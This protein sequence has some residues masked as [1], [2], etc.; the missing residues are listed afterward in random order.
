MTFLFTWL[1]NRTQ[2]SVLYSLVFHASLSTAS[3]RL[4]EVP[5]YS[6]WVLI[7]W[8]L[9]LLLLLHDR[10]LGERARLEAVDPAW[11]SQ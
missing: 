10:R 4:P 5:A 7:L 8:A 2:G 9:T 1:F 11:S 6:I 3:V